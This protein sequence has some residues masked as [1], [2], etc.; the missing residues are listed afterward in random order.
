MNDV[1]RIIDASNQGDLILPSTKTTSIVD[2]SNA[3]GSIAGIIGLT[4]SPNVSK[5]IDI[6]GTNDHLVLVIVD[7]LG[8]NVVQELGKSNS[9][10]FNTAMELVTVFPSTTST[11]LTSYAT[12]LWPSQ[13][14]VPNWHLYIKEI[15]T[16][17]TIIRFNRRYDQRDLSTLGMSPSQAYP[18]ESMVSK[19]D[20][21]TLGVIPES[22]ADTAYSTYW[23]A[24]SSYKT[25]QILGEAVDLVSS[26]VNTT[27]GST[28]T[29]LYYSEVDTL[30][31][32]NGI[33]HDLVKHEIE[34]VEFQI[35]LL[36]DKLPSRSTVIVSADH[37]LKDS[38]QQ[39]MIRIEPSDDLLNCLDREP[40]GTGR[41]AN[42]AV[43]KD[44]SNEFETRFRERFA[45]HFYLLSSS[46]ILEMNLLGPNPPSEI[47]KSR[48][49]NY[50]A[51]SKGT[52]VLDYR[53]PTTVQKTHVDQASHGG[54]SQDE[55]VVPLI[56]MK[57]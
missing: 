45:D 49:G 53:Y 10:Y 39:N 15:D 25:Y 51:I 9:L 46:E 48:I 37:G 1:Q 18:V 11:V 26:H 50:W 24:N 16:I 28:F 34:K 13:H 55:M 36:L 12:G 29:H 38:G 43:T 20:R 40:W 47:T 54:L 3:I 42:F 56:I 33:D 7:G 2:L 44:M 35:S 19:F 6:I 52:S 14:G 41:A 31:H 57:T 4:E 22:I 30:S 8:M 27:I 5:L 32:Q 21:V 17:S 23:R